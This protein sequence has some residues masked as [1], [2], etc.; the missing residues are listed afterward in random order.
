MALFAYT[1][2]CKA[3]SLF[4]DRLMLAVK[5][6]GSDILQEDTLIPSLFTC[7]TRG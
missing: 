5:M 7:I 3:F 6:K 2:E 1:Q 4:T